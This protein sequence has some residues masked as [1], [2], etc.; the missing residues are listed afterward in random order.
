MHKFK[1]QFGQNFLRNNRFPQK[2]VEYLDLKDD[3]TV[4]EIG[5]GEGILTN[6]L[7]NKDIKVIS[8]E[9]DYSLLPKLIKKFGDNP[10][11]ILENEDFLNINLLEVLK[12]NSSTK[13]IKFTGSLPYNISKKIILKILKFSFEQ[14]DY[15][16]GKMS[17]IVQEEVASDY[18][19]KAPKATQLAN[20]TSLYAKVK[21]QESI[22]KSQF[23]P[24]PQVNGGILTL[25]PHNSLPANISNIEQLIKIA[26][27]SPRK[28]LLNNL[29]N[30]KKWENKDIL[31]IL[32]EIGLNEKSRA[33]EV[34]LDSWIDLYNKLS[35]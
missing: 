29:R 35:I 7:L 34:A 19:S 30:S 13:N 3:D 14:S 9:I 31:K 23:Y 5:P 12:K 2:V 20:L 17:F 6:L 26:Y 33:S 18:N 16:V 22:P 4:I 32:N 10:N 8:I 1:K 27:I 15:N 28:T 11:F 25:E 21:K 24:V